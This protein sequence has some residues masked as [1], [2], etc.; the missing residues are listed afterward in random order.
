M[1][2]IIFNYKGERY[3]V[4]AKSCSWFEKFLGLMFKRKKN[5][6]ALSFNFETPVKIAIHSFF[7]FF[8]FI[9]IWFDDKNQVIEIKKIRPFALFVRPKKNFRRLLE[10]PLNKKYV[11]LKPLV[12]D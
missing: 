6:G 11:N 4:Y 3:E 2:K 8:P 7:V 1:E 12:D 9:A 10:I 5:A